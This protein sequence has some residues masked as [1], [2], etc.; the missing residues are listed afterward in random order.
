MRIIGVLD[1]LGGR[2]VHAH[3]GQREFYAPIS[4]VAGTAVG[5][6]DAVAIARAYLDRLGIAEL[7]VADLDAIAGRPLQEFLIAALASLG[8]P[9]WVDAGV[10]SSDQARR[11]IGLG[12]SCVIVGLETLTSFGALEDVCAAVGSDRVAFSLDLRDGQPIATSPTLSG[13]RIPVGEPT[14]RIA[15]RAAQAG[16]GAVIVID[17]AR[18][19]AGTGLDL[20][21]VIRVRRVVPAL[22][23]IAGG[24]IRGMEDLREL[25]DTGCDAALVATALHDG[26]LGAADVA[27]ARRYASRRR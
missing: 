25:A 4:A 2:A 19:G 23:L 24:G 22:M 6:G 18:V 1:L 26:R 15:A 3:G 16:A 27:A 10:A 9:V 17:L 11:V 8:V 13:N 7:Y 5:H 14:H 20:G 12:A 21:L